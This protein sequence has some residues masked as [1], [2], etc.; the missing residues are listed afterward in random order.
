MLLWDEFDVAGKLSQFSGEG[1]EDMWP[2]M[3]SV[4]QPDIQQSYPV[5]YN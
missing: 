3:I 1:R 5:S 4:I 2:F